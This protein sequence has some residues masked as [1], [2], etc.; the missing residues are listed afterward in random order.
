MRD[1]LLDQI[2]Y[3]RWAT[4]RW[5]EFLAQ[6][7]HPAELDATLEHLVDCYE[8][9]LNRCYSALGRPRVRW[10]GTLD[11]RLH[12]CLQQWVV[13]IHEE[14]PAALLSWSSSRFGD[15]SRTLGDVL[16]H[17]CNH[18]TYH[19]GQLSI[20]ARQAGLKRYPETDFVSYAGRRG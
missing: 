4:G 10:S 16:R 15:Y 20:M 7:T 3:E 18:G 2:A 11:Q 12:A 6:K 1:W 8:D 17:V 13:L 5:I 9:W 14:E 19:R